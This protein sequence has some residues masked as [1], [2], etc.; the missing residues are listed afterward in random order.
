MPRNDKILVSVEREKDGFYNHILGEH[1]WGTF[2]KKCPKENEGRVSTIF[3][4]TY[5]HDRD[6]QRHG[7]RQKWIESSW[8]DDGYC[9]PFV[10]PY[11]RPAYTTDVP[12]HCRPIPA[13]RLDGT[14]PMVGTTEWIAATVS[15]DTASRA[16]TS[17]SSTN[18]S[19]KRRN[20]KNPGRLGSLNYV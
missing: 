15:D 1:R 17:S 13:P 7:W 2:L 10:Q 8:F 9:E 3:Y 19:K 20:K 5:G 12:E 4:S 14:R 18:D 6:V 16:S 11:P